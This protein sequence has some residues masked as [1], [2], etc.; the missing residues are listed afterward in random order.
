M[1]MER[2]VL[3]PLDG[4]AVAEA[5]LPHA[6]RYARLTGSSLTLLHVVTEVERSQTDFWVAAAPSDIRRQWEQSALAG[7]HTYLATI[8][9]RLQLAGLSVRTEVP[10]ADDAAAA[11]AAQAQHDPDVALVA[12]STHGRGGLGR[13]VLGSVAAK[14]LRAVSTPVLMVRARAGVA[15][16]EA[17]QPY[18]TILIPLDGTWHAEQALTQVR[19][20]PALCDA[21]LM[22]VGVTGERDWSEFEQADI[23]TVDLSVDY[24]AG[25]LPDYLQHLARRLEA[26]GFVVRARLA[27]GATDEA[28]LRARAE[29]HADLIVT[30]ASPRGGLGRLFLQSEIEDLVRHSDVPVMIVPAD[31]TMP[32]APVKN[33]RRGT[34]EQ[35]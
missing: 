32:E 29:A 17:M 13:W 18:R 33:P 30:T 35:E 26:D 25:S 7:I 34:R 14:V 23:S 20:T 21:T 6:E 9:R 28:I 3:V 1:D 22:L 12:M 19:A 11:I 15:F 2:Q 27:V 24:E 4:S 31:R 16:Y 8:A 5:I 10:M